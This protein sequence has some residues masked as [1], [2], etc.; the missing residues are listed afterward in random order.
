MNYRRRWPVG[1]GPISSWWKASPLPNKRSDRIVLEANPDYWDPTRLP[2]L[3]RIVFDNTLAQQ[4]AVEL[5]K[6]GEGRVDL[7]T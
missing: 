4:D 6:T 2:R 1:H 5:V 3:Q 7:V